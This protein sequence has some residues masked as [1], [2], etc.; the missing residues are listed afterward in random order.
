M[1]PFIVRGPMVVVRYLV[2]ESEK[3]G[4]IVL[5][6]GFERETIEAEVMTVGISTENEY[7][8]D[9]R[10]GQKVLVRRRSYSGMPKG[11]PGGVGNFRE[12]GVPVV[13]K[14]QT[15]H[16]HN[17]REVF[18]IIRDVATEKDTVTIH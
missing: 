13:I 9:L 11:T 1:F 10:P 3:V 14:G 6:A 16:M 8:K 4:E 18:G 5:P 12:L 17:H 15:Y 7:T 2:N